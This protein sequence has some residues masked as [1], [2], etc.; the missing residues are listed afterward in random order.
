MKIAIVGI[1]G[2]VGGYV[3]EAAIGRGVE[4][5][6]GIDVKDGK[7]LSCPVYKTFD[8]VSEKVDAI[9]DFSYHGAVRSI[10]D[11][12]TDHYVP[13]VLATTGYTDDELKLIDDASKKIAIFRSGN[14][15]IG[16][17][18]LIKLVKEGAK[19]LGKS[20]DVEIIEMH[21]NRKLD[22]PSGTAIMLADAIKSERAELVNKYGRSG[23]DKRNPEDLTIHSVRG[24]TVVGVHEVLFALDN[25][26][27]SLKHTAENR[28]IFAE[29]ALDAA[30]YLLNKPCGKYDMQDMLK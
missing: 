15:S 24:G 16:I 12:A 5:A 9:V 2:V 14:M 22:A 26:V 4:V 29:G 20:A 7:E 25:E 23:Q 6:Y 1:N 13:V 11:Y 27:V 30:A 21:H 8:S 10:L 28:R 3:Y 18:L 17:N 19:A